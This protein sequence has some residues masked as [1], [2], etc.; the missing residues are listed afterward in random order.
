MFSDVGLIVGYSLGGLMLIGFIIWFVRTSRHHQTGQASQPAGREVKKHGSKTILG[1]GSLLC[2]VLKNGALRQSTI[3][4]PI[5]KLFMADPTMPK[6]GACYLIREDNNGKLTAY[7]PRTSEFDS[8]ESPQWAYFA[9]HWDSCRR[10]FTAPKA[11][12]QSAPLWITV[13]VLVILAITI[14]MAIG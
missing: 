7:D 3:P 5:G 4:E 2:Y 6:H 10:V 13:V 12:W 14:L 8:K 9:T 11:W 1:T